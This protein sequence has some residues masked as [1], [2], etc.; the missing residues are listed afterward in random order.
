MSV[1][2]KQLII[3]SHVASRDKSD[4]L[5]LIDESDLQQHE[6]ELLKRCLGMIKRNRSET[7]ER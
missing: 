5:E 2:V 4:E 1:E 6:D 7:R 3:K